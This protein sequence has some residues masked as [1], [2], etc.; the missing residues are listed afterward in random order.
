V[1]LA[2]DAQ[3][4][5]QGDSRYCDCYLRIVIPTTFH[6]SIRVESVSGNQKIKLYTLK[7]LHTKTVSGDIAID[8]VDVD[9]LSAETV[10]GDIKTRI[11][12]TSAARASDGSLELKI[13]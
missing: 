9:S 1:T 12:G 13:L 6:G 7:N 3:D 2:L 11:A 5:K 8:A 4:E 10:S